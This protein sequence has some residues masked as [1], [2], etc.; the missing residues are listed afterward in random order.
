MQDLRVPLRIGRYRLTPHVSQSQCLQDC[1]DGLTWCLEN[2]NDVL[3]EHDA[4]ADLARYI[5]AGDSAGGALSTQGGCFFK[6][7]P[8][9][10]IDVFGIVDFLEHL[11]R[12]N[13]TPKDAI[14]MP[15]YHK[16]RT[17]EEI[18]AFLRDRD[19]SRAETMSPWDW[20]LE[21]TWISKHCDD[22]GCAGLRAI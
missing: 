6:P 4:S 18:L 3:K 17:D 21:P 15:N 9:V 8:K 20:E 19:P 2:L 14:I 12:S 5:A 13:S 16:Q 7:S 1:Q 10:V 22:S 11:S